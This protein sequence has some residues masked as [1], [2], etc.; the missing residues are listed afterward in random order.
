MTS[1]EL[2]KDICTKEIRSGCYNH[3]INGIAIYNYVQRFLRKQKCREYGFIAKNKAGRIDNKIRTITL[4]RS[5]YQ[6]FSLLLLKKDIRNF[7]YAFPRVDEVYGIYLDKFTDPVIDNSI[8]KDQGYVIFE[9]GKNYTHLTPRE[10]S[11]KVIYCDAIE[12]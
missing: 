9:K 6:L 12:F 8:I 11:D 3:T 4:I 7:I 2:I 5:S 10:H 1:D